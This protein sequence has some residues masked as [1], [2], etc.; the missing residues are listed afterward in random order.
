MNF[1]EFEQSCKCFDCGSPLIEEKLID[2]FPDKELIN[3]KCKCEYSFKIPYD[4]NNH[5]DSFLI[6]LPI[7]APYITPKGE[8][9]L[10]VVTFDIDTGKETFMITF[11]PYEPSLL[12]NSKNFKC[13]YIPDFMSLPK[14]ELLKKMDELLV[15]I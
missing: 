14:D 2:H 11:P 6:H 12:D 8:F 5:L 7:T 10:T 4:K 3:Y 15:F 1:K 9:R 13:D